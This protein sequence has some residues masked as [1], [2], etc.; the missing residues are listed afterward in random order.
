MEYYIMSISNQLTF[1]KAKLNYLK[2]KFTLV[3]HFLFLDKDK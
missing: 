3:V 2:C 1:F